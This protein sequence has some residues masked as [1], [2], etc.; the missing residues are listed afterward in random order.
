MDACVRMLGNIKEEG[1]IILS[2][3]GDT[4]GKQLIFVYV[5]RHFFAFRV[6]E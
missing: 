5:T 4:F 3:V 1:G 6:D 2:R